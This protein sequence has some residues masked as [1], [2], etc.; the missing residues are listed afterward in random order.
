MIKYNYEYLRDSSFL[1]E[2]DKNPLK[3]QYVKITVL[4]WNEN[5]IKAIEG[6][7]TGGSVN[8]NGDS[9]MRRSCNLTMVASDNDYSITTVRNLISINKRI[10]LEIGF[11]NTTSKYLK[12]D[13]LW[14]P[15]GVYV[16]NSLNIV[17]GTDGTNI[18]LQLQDK[19]CLLN[20]TCG[21]IIPAA[22]TFHQYETVDENGAYIIKK[23]TI[24]AIIQELV[25]HFGGE[26]LSKIIISDLDLRIKHVMKWI[27]S[28][29]IY[30]QN[31]D[32]GE[33]IQ[34]NFTTDLSEIDGGYQKYEN[35][36]DI[37][38]IYT[39]F[40]YPSELIANAGDSVTSVLDKITKVLTNYEYFYDLQGNF[41]FREKKNYLNTSKSTVDLNNINKEDY[42]IDISKEKAEYVFDNSTLISSF[43]NS[44]KYNMIK[45]D[46]IVWGIKTDTLG[47]KFPI[48]YHLAIDSKPKTGNTYKC[49]FYEDEKDGLKKTKC[50]IKYS[51]ITE[52]PTV[53]VNDLFYMDENDSKIYKWDS[54]KK[55]YVQITDGLVDITTSD[56]RTELYLQGASAEPLGAGSNDYYTELNN[57]WPK[58]YDV[59]KGEFTEEASAHPTDVNYFLDF[60]DSE[61][62]ISEISISNIG[63]RSQVVND[64]SVNCIFEPLIPDLVILDNSNPDIRTLRQECEEQGQ[65]YV[66]VDSNIFSNIAAGGTKNSAFVLVRDLLYQYTS[67]NESISISALPIYYLE[68]NTRIT[69]LDQ[70]SDIYGDY[71]IKSMSLPLIPSGTMSLS[72]TRALDKI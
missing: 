4:D 19:M 55:E 5:P 47:N 11:L 2:F 50:P 72:C 14:F 21:G 7:T 17:H 24:Y 44:P 56:W 30:L 53:G 23:P 15:L 3:E 13:K 28:T 45:N 16:I 69:V 32:D 67:Y 63:K 70:E 46:F 43:N 8:V 39:D 59:E 1:K 51:N 31:S 18:S 29:P 41:I 26:Q 48:R 40:T 52:F 6:R 10:H 33:S 25:N 20:G 35:G 71:I 22:T 54:E 12:Y 57:E 42:L 58:L 64:E 49:F 38:Y 66:Q 27:G 62:S 61:A 68:P 37:G 60:I 34:Y 9:A 36:E 65:D